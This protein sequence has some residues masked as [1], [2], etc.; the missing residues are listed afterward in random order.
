MFSVRDIYRIV[1]SILLISSC[2][3]F[4]KLIWIRIHTKYRPTHHCVW[5]H[6]KKKILYT[7]TLVLVLIHWVRQYNKCGITL[8]EIS[9][10]IDY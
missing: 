3:L 2:L 6:L 9:G 10:G 7:F 4:V 1:V 8:A 5:C